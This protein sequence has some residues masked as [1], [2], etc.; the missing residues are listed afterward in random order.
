[1]SVFKEHFKIVF[2]AA[3]QHP[4]DLTDLKLALTG[5]LEQVEVELTGERAVTVVR[6]TPEE[7]RVA[8][9]DPDFELDDFA[10]DEIA[11]D[12][13]DAILANNYWDILRLTVK[14]IFS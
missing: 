14:E 1:M 8:V 5:M 10:M 2:D 13:L 6:L 9:G 3:K 11:S 12:L 4:Q 7:V